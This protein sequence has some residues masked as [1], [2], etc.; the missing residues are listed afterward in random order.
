MIECLEPLAFQMEANIGKAAIPALEMIGKTTGTFNAD[1]RKT[2]E[3]HD[4][5]G[6]PLII[7]G[8]GYDDD[9]LFNLSNAGG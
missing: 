8:L 9:G 3:F 6:Y 2:D 7:F 5:R 4:A 1:C